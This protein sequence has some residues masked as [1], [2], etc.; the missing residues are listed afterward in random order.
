MIS[1][2]HVHTKFSGDSEADVDKVILSAINKGMP[3]LAITDHNDFGYENGTFEL[4]VE[5]YFRY[6]SDKKMEYKNDICISIGIECG[7]EP[8]YENRINNLK[9][10][11][12][13]DFVIGSSHTVGGIDPYYKEYFENRAVH[14]AMIEQLE[15]IIENIEIFD[16]FDVYGHLDYVM[17]YAPVDNDKK[18]YSYEEYDV[19]FDKI[20]HNLIKKGKGIEINTSPLRSG[21]SD[22]NP[23]IQV[24]KK[25]KEYG[26]KIIT[27]GADAHKPEDIGA[28]F[29]TAEEM[30][31]SAG[32]TYYNIFS[33][34]KAVE[35]SL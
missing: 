31:K 33:D 18:R 17:R 27:V 35:I 1:D 5:K 23:N 3:Y 25:Y 4:D 14:D 26:G 7:L 29:N 6:I 24:L 8:K 34:R 2:F 19:L 12:D 11:Y 10:S 32:F 28:D 30:L 21:L 16:S 13:F 22:A 15:S 20:L 9:K